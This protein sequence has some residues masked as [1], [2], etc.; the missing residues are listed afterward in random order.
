M[1]TDEQLARV[2]EQ[3]RAAVAAIRPLAPSVT[4]AIAASVARARVNAARRREPAPDDERQA[5]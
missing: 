3:A 1:L 5:S 4:R 2:R